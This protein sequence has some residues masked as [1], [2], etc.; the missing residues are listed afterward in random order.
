MKPVEFADLVVQRL[1]GL[2]ALLSGHF[3]RFVIEE[4]DQQVDRIQGIADFVRHARGDLF[5]RRIAF[6]HLLDHAVYRVGQRLQLVPG[7]HGCSRRVIAFSQALGHVGDVTYRRRNA[8]G[9]E[10]GHHQ[11]RRAASQRDPVEA[12]AHVVQDLQLL[13][14]GVD[15]D[16]GEQLAVQI[17]DG[18][19][20][21]HTDTLFRLISAGVHGGSR[22]QL[23]SERLVEFAR[24]EQR[25]DRRAFGQVD[26]RAQV[27]SEHG[28]VVD[29][30]GLADFLEPL[31]Q[32]QYHTSIVIAYAD[33]FQPF[34]RRVTGG[35]A[36]HVLQPAADFL[37]QMRARSCEEQVTRHNRHQQDQY[38]VEYDLLLEDAASR[39]SPSGRICG[40]EIDHSSA[41]YIPRLMLSCSPLPVIACLTWRRE[42]SSMVTEFPTIVPRT[43]PMATSERKCRLPS[44]RPAATRTLESV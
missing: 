28:D 16:D 42:P 44:S 29:P 14:A 27:G 5:E 8:A 30:G 21:R 38:D 33:E 17:G 3:S 18:C 24:L 12:R 36:R 11:S 39:A 10:Q 26:Q 31:L 2:G 43:A 6:A 19:V 9:E 35:D 4:G 25:A 7:R 1:D 20:G 15:G 34:E 32:T 13:R 22:A 40:S 41:F 37:L 23:V